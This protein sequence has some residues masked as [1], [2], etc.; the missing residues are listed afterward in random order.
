[1]D[2]KPPR[3]FGLAQ[4]TLQ[5]T[6]CFEASFFESIKVTSYTCWIS[7]ARHGSRHA[8]IC[9]L[10]YVILNRPSNA[11]RLT[12][13]TLRGMKHA[14]PV[15]NS[16]RRSNAM[17]RSRIMALVV[18]LPLVALTSQSLL[19][20]GDP[21]TA[22]DNQGVADTP[23]GGVPTADIIF[24]PD[25]AAIQNNYSVTL[26]GNWNN[27]GTFDPLN[28]TVTFDG[29]ANQSVTKVGGETFYNFG[30]NKSGGTLTLNNAATVMNT[31]TMFGKHVIPHFRAKEKA[32]ASSKTPLAGM[33]SA[34][35]D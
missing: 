2:I 6:S 16:P 7:H 23:T 28:G 31:L 8:S 29:G 17:P 12:P 20:Q 1:M 9:Q 32:Q 5:Q 30:V 34:A 18:L 13:P 3:C 26:A 15:D 10:Y 21:W 19:A 24:T 22:L 33:S 4:T 14:A 25:S 11:A 35:N 27:T